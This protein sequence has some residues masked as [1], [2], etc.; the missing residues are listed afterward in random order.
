MGS[1]VQTTGMELET[2]RPG[3]DGLEVK[4]AADLNMSRAD[5]WSAE[6]PAHNHR[7]PVTAAAQTKPQLKIYRFKYSALKTFNCA[8]FVVV[9][10]LKVVVL[11]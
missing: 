1:N 9:T 5:L 11:L 3:F 7:C 8:T 6:R 2:V 4:A 10:A